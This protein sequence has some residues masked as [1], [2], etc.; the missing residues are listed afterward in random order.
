MNEYQVLDSIIMTWW[1]L[2]NFQ[3]VDQAMNNF[4][5]SLVLNSSS[6]S[7]IPTEL[8]TSLVQTTEPL[9]SVCRDPRAEWS[10]L[11]LQKRSHGL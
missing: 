10:E 3:I 2:W 8:H 1:E 9:F 7:T 5:S 4:T 6:S 11:G